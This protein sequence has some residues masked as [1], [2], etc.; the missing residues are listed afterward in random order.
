MQAVASVNRNQIIAAA[1][2]TLQMLQILGAAQGAMTLR[3]VVAASGRP[4]VTVHR[5]LSTLVNTGFATY[6]SKSRLYTLTLKAWSI[7]CTALRDF[8]LIERASPILGELRAQTCETV[9]ISI[10]EPCCDIVYVSKLTSP[11]SIVGQTRVGQLAPAWCTATGRAILAFRQSAA[12]HVLTRA[13]EP[14]TPKTVTDPEAILRILETVRCNGYSVTCAENHP[15]MG[16][17]AAPVRS[18]SGEV[19]GSVGAAVPVYRMTE[20]A[21]K[22]ITPP[23]REAAR[24]ISKAMGYEDDSVSGQPSA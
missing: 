12:N 17:V 1:A 3:S 22:A 18:R 7:G 20:Y 24:L 16:G 14:R 2:G 19:I 23:V 15:E 5:M 8:D 4:R 11:N 21:V 9:H 10:L 6:S 13:L